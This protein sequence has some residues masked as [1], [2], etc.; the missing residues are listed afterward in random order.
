MWIL[1]VENPSNLREK[2]MIAKNRK[3]IVGIVAAI[4]TFFAAIVTFFYGYEIIR[5][6]GKLFV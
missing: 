3:I 6:K 2:T 1:M 5:N 4:I